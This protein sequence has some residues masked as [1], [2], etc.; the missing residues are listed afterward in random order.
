MGKAFWLGMIGG[1]LGFVGAI[2]AVLVGGISAA[3]SS[4]S[5]STMLYGLG[6]SAF[7]FSIVGCFNMLIFLVS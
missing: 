6:L 1:F 3:Y 2:I 7:I 5:E 4:S